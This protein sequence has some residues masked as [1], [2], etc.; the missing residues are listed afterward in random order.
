MKSAGQE[1]SD[2]GQFSFPC[3]I[4]AHGKT[5]PHKATSLIDSRAT[6]EFI[7]ESFVK[8]LG[9]PRFKLTHSVILEVANGEEADYI[10]EGAQV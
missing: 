5:T 1:G 9:A 4:T 8:K 2:N 7:L 6:F 10:T 3:Q